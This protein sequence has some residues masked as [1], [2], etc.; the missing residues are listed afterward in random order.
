MN[1][2]DNLSASLHVVNSDV[3]FDV[4]RHSNFHKVLKNYVESDFLAALT[5]LSVI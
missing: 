3:E 1:H 5:L 4:T 2:N